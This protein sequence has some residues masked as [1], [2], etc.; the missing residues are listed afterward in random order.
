[1]GV[2]YA[3]VRS[4]LVL[5]PCLPAHVELWAGAAAIEASD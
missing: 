5:T 4:F 3:S 1:M 2:K